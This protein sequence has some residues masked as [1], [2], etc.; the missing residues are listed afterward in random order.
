MSLELRRAWR[1]I[2]ERAGIS[3]D[4]PLLAVSQSLGVV[5]RSLISEDDPR[6]DDLSKYKVSAAGDLVLS[7]FNAYRGAL[8]L[9]PERGLVSPDY[10]VLRALPGTSNAY[11]RYLL[12]SDGL[13]SLMRMSVGGIGA[14]DPDSSGFSRIDKKIFGRAAVPVQDFGEQVAI[15]GFLDRETAQIDAMIEAQRILVA[16]LIERRLSAINTLLEE[17]GGIDR[18]PLGTVVTIQTGIT[19]G[20]TYEGESELVEYPYL[21]VANVQTGHVNT[22]DLTTILLPPWEAHRA[23]LRAGDVLITEGGDR[24]ALARGSLWQGEVDPCLHQ[25]HI[26]A[27]RPK[28]DRLMAKYLVYVLESS[29][30]RSHFERTR[31]QTTNLSATNSSLVRAFR[32]TLPSID[33]QRRLVKTLD[34]TA[35]RMDALIDVAGRSIDLLRERRAALI[36]AAVTGRLDPRTGVERLDD[37]ME[38]AAS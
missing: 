16:R 32:F 17:A 24:A 31:R 33:D 1:E 3:A 15:A 37:I 38:V 29:L 12:L 2:D 25:N 13:K 19:L 34:Q 23:M 22:D 10:L 7:R 4:L 5:R 11:L 21:R 18:T 14:T 35:A 28:A 20:K 30:A 6:A 27:L 26:Y 9:A 36:T 8:G